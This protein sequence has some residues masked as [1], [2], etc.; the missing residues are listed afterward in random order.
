MNNKKLILV[1]FL[2]F[3]LLMVHTI[4]WADKRTVGSVMFVKGVVTAGPKDG[5][6]RILGKGMPLYETDI[7]TTGA[8]SFIMIKMVDDSRITLRS[9]TVL[10]LEKY[11]PV[12][13]KEKAVLRLFKGGLRAI[14]GF[15]AKH[16]P[17]RGFLVKSTT[18]VLGIRGTE[19]DARLCEGDCAAEEK[20]MERASGAPQ[21]QVIGRVAR[22]KGQ[23]VALGKDQSTRRLL[24]G[25]PL[26]VGDVLK[27]GPKDFAV[28]VFRDNTR[29]TLQADSSFLVEKYNYKSGKEDNSFFRLMRGG[30]RVFTG[31]IA[32]RNRK[33]FGV[34][35]PTA[36][37]GI[38]GT[39]FDLKL[40]QKSKTAVSRQTEKSGLYA[41]V[42]QGA[43]ETKNNAGTTEIK[44]NQI[45]FLAGMNAKPSFLKAMPDFMRFNPEL[46]PDKIQ[47]DMKN[48][49][50]TS[51]RREKPPGLYVS[52][53]DGHVTLEN[54]KGSID[55]GKG[56]AGYSDPQQLEITRLP[57][58]P[59]FQVNDRIPSPKMFD[60][61]NNSFSN[62][63]VNE[64][65]GSKKK[66][67]IECEIR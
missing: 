51:E 3:S 41:Y 27:T 24:K 66:K 53:Y 11:S 44:K 13:G 58:L 46:R 33:A 56:E 8:H 65:G 1:C 25:G 62:F 34:G 61:N 10:A 43:I 4:A 37:L 14:T 19:F 6:V 31:L 15:I 63:I 26:Y 50:G 54:E 20:S 21:S 64:P 16:N 38:R 23:L 59:L 2:I 36:V 67:E 57:Q 42:W 55:L 5:E 60:Q 39:G 30:L 12:K 47:V 32:K 35:T 49:F 48:L 29:V 9:D 40:M 17:R 7:L 52:V 18:A 45:I 22:L 28:L